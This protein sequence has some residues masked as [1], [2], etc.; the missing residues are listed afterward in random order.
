M[1]GIR[2]ALRCVMAALA[3][4]LAPA[5]ALAGPWTEPEGAGLA[6]SRR[7]TDNRQARLTIVSYA[8]NPHRRLRAFS[9]RDIAFAGGR[10]RLGR[11]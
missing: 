10:A 6:F 2:N 1:G 5:S 3:A 11:R 9:P 7:Q 4:L 8:P